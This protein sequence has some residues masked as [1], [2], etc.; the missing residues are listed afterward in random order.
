MKTMI[1]LKAQ[2]GKVF[3]NVRTLRYVT[4]NI[5]TKPEFEKD[6]VQIDQRDLKQFIAETKA[7]KE[8]EATPLETSEVKTE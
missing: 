1:R 3:V 6:W 4:C 2:S 8:A 7:Q 5:Y